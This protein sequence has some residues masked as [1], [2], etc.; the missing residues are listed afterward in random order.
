MSRYH[1]TD[2]R[3]DDPLDAGWRAPDMAARFQVD[4]QG[5]SPRRF[6]HSERLRFGVGAPGAGVE[7]LGEH[8]SVANE[9][10]P[11][12][13]VR[14]GGVLAERCEFERSPH[15]SFVH[16][17]DR[18][19]SAPLRRPPAVDNPC[20]AMFT[21]LVIAVGEVASARDVEGGGRRLTVGD[22]SG[23]LEE[24]RV[25]DSVAVAGVCLTA[26][27]SGQGSVSF[28][29]AAETLARTTLG[30]ARPGSRLNLELPLRASDRLGGHFVQGHVD[31]VGEVL[32]AGGAEADYRVLLR[33]EE[34]R[35]IV[36]KGSVALD[37]VSL[38]VSAS[39]PREARF[40]VMLIPHTRAATTLGSLRQGDRVNL[41]Y[42]ILAK[43]IG[44]RA[45]AACG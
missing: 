44:A 16:G 22:A 45:L 18:M 23:L 34:P 3:G 38:T 8:L 32:K 21:G 6:A 37:G 1:P 33:H 35:W 42:D 25:G 26:V 12:R 9:H 40:E 24:V 41:E 4:E 43:Y 5:G 14:G 27:A 10:R 31:G 7:S 39:F 20:A 28:E 13:R 17:P 11:D 36:P 2:S 15:E 19:G 30:S 29:V